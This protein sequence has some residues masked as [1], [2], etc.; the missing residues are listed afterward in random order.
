MLF[1]SDVYLGA[2]VGI[3]GPF[4]AFGRLGTLGSFTPHRLR[5]NGELV[6]TLPSISGEIAFGVGWR[7]L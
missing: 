2:E 5:V 7:I 4:Y 6:F 1:R 3:A